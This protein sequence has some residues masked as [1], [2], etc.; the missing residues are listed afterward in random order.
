MRAGKRC[1]AG[2]NSPVIDGVGSRGPDFDGKPRLAMLSKAI[3][4]QTR[5][6][7][8]DVA[9]KAGV[10][11]TT[12]SRALKNDA[13]VNPKTL[14]KVR[15]I[16]EQMGYM[17]DPMLSALN[18]YRHASRVS[19]YHGTVA[20]VTNFSTRGGW[21][22]SCFDLYFQGA[23]EQLMRHGYRLEE[24]WLREPGMTA[25]RL[26]QV[27]FQRGIR[28]LLICPLEISR[29]H[30]SLQ[31]ERF[32]AVTFGYSLVR[33]RLH[34]FSA[35]H[36]YATIAAMHQL[37]TLGYRRIGM[38]ASYDFDR[39]MNRMLT[40]AYQVELPKLPRSQ[41][42]PI[43]LLG[44]RDR[45]ITAADKKN[46]PLILKWY[47]SYKPEVIVVTPAIPV[48]AW[49]MEEGYRVPED[50]AVANLSFHSPGF[51]SGIIEPSEEIG[52]AAANFLAAMLQRGEYG[53][54]SIPQRV[55]LEGKWFTGK[56]TL[57]KVPGSRPA[58]EFA[59]ARK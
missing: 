45:S 48:S 54:P 31:W 25:R 34:L 51:D 13:R 53:I 24:F 49:L 52:R 29:G 55:L 21:H 14:A 46:K 10:H 43:C 9:A 32:S 6:T 5:V 22:N 47:R 2:R 28:G 57:P 18:A 38:V 44:D 35:S 23:S 11:Q 4:M 56:S 1:P 15:T 17:P 37:R 8:R 50:V 27:L 3:P 36:Y 30:L 33:P 16:A 19:L 12:A 40:A 42:L 39:R 58:A 20:W 59:S 7:L 26:S 41:A